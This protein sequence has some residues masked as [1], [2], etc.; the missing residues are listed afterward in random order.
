MLSIWSLAPWAFTRSLDAANKVKS[1]SWVLI[2]P[3]ASSL[4]LLIT[5]FV[6][7]EYSASFVFKSQL[8]NNFSTLLLLPSKNLSYLSRLVNSSKVLCANSR[9]EFFE[10]SLLTFCISRSWLGNV[11]V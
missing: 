5:V 4:D 8:S 11:E 7:D 2:S 6:I 10:T 3:L 1:S 9:S